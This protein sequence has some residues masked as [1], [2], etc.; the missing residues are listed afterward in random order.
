MTEPIVVVGGGGFGREVLDVIEAIN[1]QDVNP[2]FQLLGVIDDSPSEENLARL[3]TRSVKYLG[4]ITEFLETEQNVAYAIG[5]GSP[6]T[7]RRV[8]ALLDEAG[9]WPAILVHPS[10]TMGAQVSIAAGTVICAGVRLTT[11]IAIGCHVHI[12]LNATIGHD[13]L[14]S[15]FVSINPLASISG[16]CSLEADVMVGVGGV[17]LQGL[18]IGEGSV[19]GACAC[20]VRDVPPGVVVKGVPAR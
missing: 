10:V 4:G 19:V 12:N 8:A 5:I 9:C 15:D 14:I 17:I 18:R 7:R 13:T 6:R 20:V 3:A 16:G 11:N 2:P 1:S